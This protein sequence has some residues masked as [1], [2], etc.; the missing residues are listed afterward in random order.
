[1]PLFDVVRASLDCARMSATGDFEKAAIELRA[2]CD[3]ELATALAAP[4]DRP[5]G[6]ALTTL[7]ISIREFQESDSARR[8][9]WAKTLATQSQLVRDLFHIA[10]TEA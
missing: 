7:L 8:A 9:A 2:Q 1:M 10:G 4:H 6:I 3:R 5:L